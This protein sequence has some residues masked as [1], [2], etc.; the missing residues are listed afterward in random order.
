MIPKTIHFCWLSD[1]PYPPKIQKCIESWHRYL[2]EYEFVHWN[3]EKLYSIGSEWAIEA[4]ENKKYAF[5]ADFIRCYA[6]YNYGGIYLDTDVEVCKPLTPILDAESFMGIDSRG[7]LEAAVFGAVPGVEWL[8][9]ALDF[10]EGRHFVNE[11]GSFNITTMPNVFKI[12]LSGE[13]PSDINT[14][15][16]V[17]NFE[18]ITLYPAE[19]FSPKDYTTG[20]VRK[21]KKTFT[22][23]HF[24]CSWIPNRQ[25]FRHKVK[26]FLISLFGEKLITKVSRLL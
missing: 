7:D 20:T 14:L 16:S 17:Q 8:K 1:D 10:Y 4:F 9:R 3:K 18:N 15:T 2:P 11:D 24:A 19:Y 13:I 26:L 21:T 5:A 25:L 22:I 12:A 23:H 6:T